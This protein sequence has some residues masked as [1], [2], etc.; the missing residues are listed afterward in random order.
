MAVAIG[1]ASRPVLCVAP[2]D[3][4]ASGCP[5]AGAAHYTRVTVPGG[6][7]FGSDYD[8]LAARIAAFVGANTPR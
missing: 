5:A 6:H 3:D 2:E 8:A 7:H 1:R 4:P